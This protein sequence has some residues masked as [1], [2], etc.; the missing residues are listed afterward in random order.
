MV[1]KNLE[2]FHVNEMCTEGFV[3]WKDAYTQMGVNLTKDEEIHRVHQGDVI[4]P[5]LFTAALEDIFKTFDWDGKGIYVY[6]THL[7]HLRYADDVLIIAECA[8]HLKGMLEELY[9]VSLK[10]GLKMKME[11]TKVMATTYPLENPIIL[12]SKPLEQVKKYIYLAQQIQLGRDSL[13]AEI[14]RRI[15]L[16]WAAF[17]KLRCVFQSKLPQSLKSKVFT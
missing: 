3:D 7:N 17:G 13:T 12:G 9:H 10:I 4:S 1:R 6:G 15:D 14:E 2:P 11:K 5:K 8:D 16:G